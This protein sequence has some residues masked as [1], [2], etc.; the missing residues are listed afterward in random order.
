LLIVV[1]ACFNLASGLI[2]MVNEKRADIAILLSQ[3][4]QPRQ[5]IAVFVIQAL[6]IALLGLLLGLLAGG[7]LLN[8][9]GDAVL[10]LEALLKVDLTS[11][12]PVH[13]LPSQVLLSDVLLIAVSVLVL[14]VLASLYPAWLAARVKPAEELKYE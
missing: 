11:A 10:G 14:S 3:G 1:V 7:L 8:V 6:L 4:L 12:Y 13:Y 2:M 5:L 9:L